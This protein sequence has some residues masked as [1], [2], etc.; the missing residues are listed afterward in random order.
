MIALEEFRLV[1]CPNCGQSV[2]ESQRFCG[3]CGT[4]VQ[5]ALRAAA[6]ASTAAEEESVPYAYTQPTGYGYESAPPAQAPLGNRMIV[7][8]GALILAVCCAFA[9]G[10]VL[11]FEIIPDLMGLGAPS[12]GPTP[13]PTGAPTPSSLLPIVRYLI[14]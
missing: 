7:V 13:R 3:T 14:G 11:G 4:D 2:R 5:A 6:P 10:L 8:V 12:V 1:T 9:C